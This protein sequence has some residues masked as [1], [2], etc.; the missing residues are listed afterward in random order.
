M[1][2]GFAFVLLLALAI[3]PARAAEPAAADV[4]RL[5]E[6]MQVETL[7]NDTMQQMGEMHAEMVRNA[8][9]KNVPEAQRASMQA[10][11]AR[12]QERT[13][14]RMAWSNLGPLMRK[15][16]V[17]VYTQQEVDA[18]IAF[19]GSPTG[20][21]ILRKT[22]QVSTMMMQAMQPLMQEMMVELKGEL[23]AE[24]AKRKD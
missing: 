19:Y 6:V 16:Y 10:F 8:F 17:E 18:M 13:R 12:T 20:A 15:V 5:L 21:A 3:W 24:L 22:P 11:L 1:P 2:Y 14:Q 4:D 23:D 9:G 7:M